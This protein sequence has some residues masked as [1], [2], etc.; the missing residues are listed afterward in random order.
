LRCLKLLKGDRVYKPRDMKINKKTGFVAAV[1]VV[2][3]LA[4]IVL[5]MGQGR[6]ASKSALKVMAEN[7]DLQVKNILLTEVGGAGEK[8]EIKAETAQYKRKENLALFDKVTVKLVMADGKTFIMTGDKGK[9]MTE[10]KDME[11]SGNVVITSEQGDRF[12]TDR[13]KYSYKDKKVYSDGNVTMDNARMTVTGVGM[14][15]LM[16]EKKIKILSNVKVVTK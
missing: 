8:W 5:F 14:N 10:K 7:V 13:M 15:L 2:F 6:D 11:I 9:F 12:T 16:N 1:A 4:A 3:I